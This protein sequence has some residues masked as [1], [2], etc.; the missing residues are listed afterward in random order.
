MRKRWENGDLD[1]KLTVCDGK[2]PFLMGKST[3]FF[4]AEWILF[5]QKVIFSGDVMQNHASHKQPTFF[6]GCHHVR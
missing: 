5:T 4:F 3:T 1:G 6:L 2:S